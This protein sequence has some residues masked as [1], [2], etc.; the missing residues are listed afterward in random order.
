M[1]SIST[2]NVV[3]CEFVAGGENNKHVLVNAFSGDI[4]VGDLPARINLGLY[5][6]FVPDRDLENELIE[7]T[8]YLDRV[9]IVSVPVNVR[10]AKKSAPSLIVIQ[11]FPVITEK[12][13]VL[14]VVISQEGYRP[15]TALK[16]TISK[17]TFRRATV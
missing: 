11:Q 4:V 1:K 12:D 16:K 9:A 14:K 8:V 5:L 17:G 2:G 7:L 13:A 6:E 15:T 10:F 3:L